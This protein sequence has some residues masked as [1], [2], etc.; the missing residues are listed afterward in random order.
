M[1][2]GVDIKKMNDFGGGGGGRGELGIIFFRYIGKSDW[3][4]GFL[5]N[6]ME[7]FNLKR[8]RY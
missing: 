2:K 6:K 1:T 5:H 7:K 4:V 3:Q 8:F